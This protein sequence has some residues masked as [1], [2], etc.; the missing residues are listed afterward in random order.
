[1]RLNE[2]T[3][4]ELSKMLKNKKCSAKE[5]A[6][7]VFRQINEREKDI[8]AYITVLEDEALKQAE[9][10]DKKL[11]K[12]ETVSSLAGIPIG[13]KDAICMKNTLTTCASKILSNFISP[14]D[15]TVI[16]RLRKHDVVFTGKLNLDEFAM[17]SS[18]EYSYFGKTKNPLNLEYVPG[19]SSSG[20]VAS[21]AGNE[22][23]MSLGSD[24]GGSIRVPA[25]FCGLVGLKPTYGAVSRYGLIA[26]AS[27]L[28]QIGPVA[29]TVDDAAMLYRAICGYDEKDATTS[30]IN[31]NI[32][33]DLDNFDVKNL[34]IGISEEYFGDGVD[35]DVVNNVKK[36]IKMFEE[37]GAI[38][39][40]V[41]LPKGEEAIAAYYIILPSE[42]SSNL[43]RFDGV[44]YG[45]R[46]DNYDNLEEMYEKTREEGFGQEV[47][48][49][50]LLGT[51]ILSANHRDSI[52]AKGKFFQRKVIS[53]MKNI[54]EDCDIVITPSAPSTAFKFGEMVNDPVKMYMNDMCA[55]FVNIAGLPA[56]SLPCGVGKNGM[57][58]GIQIIGPHFSE[59]LLFKVGKVHEKFGIN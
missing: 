6:K 40:E 33:E 28:D 32:D 37:R 21:V 30:K 25:A 31:H 26:L 27:S 8:N 44:K 53:E 48:R 38:I 10:V 57:P 23:I 18:G 49:R 47:K 46:T 3:A 42:A 13:V 12:G 35:Q 15:A 50:I 43:A 9:I 51:F 58:I 24:T 1:M 36:S 7:D 34:R 14:Y 52:Y 59:N 16:E 29:K 55:V 39:K 22:A 11:A 4:K 5:I 54:F 20:P 56:I 17:G 45:Y 19:G 2:L 41:K